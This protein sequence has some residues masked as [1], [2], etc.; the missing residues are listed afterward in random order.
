MNKTNKPQKRMQ[1]MEHSE[2][3]VVI[4]RPIVS[5]KC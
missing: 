2:L 5:E 1:K 4:T 3:A